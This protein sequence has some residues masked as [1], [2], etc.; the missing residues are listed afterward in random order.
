MSR[1][2][3]FIFLVFL[4]IPTF[5]LAADEMKP[6]NL[7]VKFGDNAV[8]FSPV[9]PCGEKSF[10]IP[11]ISDYISALYQ[12]SVGIA[13]ILAMVMIMVGGFLWLTSAGSPDRV[14]KAKEFITSA[15]MG[16]ALALFSF[17]ILYTI[18]P[19]LVGLQ[20]LELVSTTEREAWKE[21]EK[22][23]VYA[24]CKHE[25]AYFFN[26]S[27]QTLPADCS[28]YNFMNNINLMAIAAAE[29]GCNPNAQSPAG[30]CGLMQLL[31]ATASRLAGRNVTCDELKSNPDLS[32]QLANKYINQNHSVHQG[33][34]YHIAAGYNSGFGTQPTAGGLPALA[35]SVDCPGCYAYECKTKPGGLAETQKYVENVVSYRNGAYEAVYGSTPPALAPDII[36]SG[37]SEH[38]IKIK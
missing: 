12:Y 22:L 14:G 26:V 11:W 23:G 32:I 25:N 31:P 10:C 7:V 1:I 37:Q 35:R 28:N 5:V 24:D 13:A 2:I 27:S 29:S 19:R 3:R 34:L 17:V 33:N 9:Q 21:R 36:K 4:L 18:N 8:T 20:G 16:L 38:R 15:I 30:A 6:P